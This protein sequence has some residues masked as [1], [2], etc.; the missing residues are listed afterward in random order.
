[1]RRQAPFIALFLLFT[2]FVVPGSAQTIY[3]AL[4]GAVTDTTGSALP[5]ATVTALNTST[6]ISTVRKA[7]SSG[8]YIFTQ[9]QVGGPYTV[10][11]AST[12]F[13][14]FVATGLILN[15]ND[16]REVN[17]KL[18]VGSTAQTVEV[19]ASALQVETSSTQLQQVATE[20]QLQEIPLLGRDPAGLQKLQPGVVESSDRIG[21]YSSNGSQT[22]QNSYLLNGMDINDGAL[23]SEGLLINPDAL[24]EESIVTS[25]MNPE[26]ARNSGA[27]INQLIKAGSNQFHGSGFEFYRDTFLN[28][29]NYFSQIRPVYHQN[30][31]GGTLGGPIFKDRFFFFLAYQGYRH[32]T[33]ETENPTTFTPNQFAGNFTDDL[34]FS[35]SNPN[36]AG[37]TNNPIPV[38]VNGC[39]A[40]PNSATPT[41]WASCFN[42]GSVVIPTTEWNTIAAN[43]V[44]KYI[45]A[46]NT[47]SG[48]YTFNALN[49][50][51]QD[52]GIIR[53]DYTPS[54]R[55]AVWGAFI[56]QSSPNQNELS[57]G[58]GSFPGFGQSAAEHY[59]IANVSYTHTFNANLLNELRV[60]Y[61]RFNFSAVNPTPVQSPGTLGFHITPQNSLSGIPYLNIGNNSLFELGNSFEGPQPRLDTNLSYA[62]SVTWVRGN[63]SLKFGGMW[64][65]FRVH[66][67]F[68]LD[69]NGAYSYGGGGPYSSG[70]PLIDFVM[71]I[72]DT[73]TQ[74]NNGFIDAV[75]TEAYA[76]VQDNWKASPD[77]TLNLGLAW[78]AEEPN[79]NKQFSG[80]G[81]VCYQIS[82]ATS[83]VFPGGAPGLFYNGDPGCNEAGGP[84]THY[85]HFAPKVGFAWSPSSGPAAL[86]G[87]PGSHNFSIRGAFGVYFNRD[88]EEQSLQN[89]ENPPAFFTSRGAGDFG[90]SPAFGN[91]FADVAGNGFET[92][93]FPYTAPSAGA[94]VNWNLYNQLDL[95]AFSKNYLVPYTYNFNLNIQR[96]IGSNMV[97]QIGYVGSLSHRLPTW[98]EG[99]PITQAGHDAC[100]ANAACNPNTIHQFFPQYT[101]NPAIVPGTAN[102][103]LPNGLPWYYS[104]AQQNTEGSSNYNSLQASLIK[105]PTHGLQFTLSYTYSHALDN[106]S[107]YESATGGD[108]GYG[109]AGRVYNYVPGFQAL[110]YGSSDFDARHRFVASYV[111]SVPVMSFMKDNF[112]LRQALSGWGVAGVTALQ[113]GFPIGLNMGAYRSYWCDA[114]SYFGC[115]D[116]PQV[117]D[118]NEKIFNPR[119]TPGVNQYFDTT[120]ISAE[121]LGTFG[122]ATRNYFHG[123]GFNYTNLSIIKGFPLSAEN[124][125]R[126]ELRLEAYNVFNHANFAPPVNTFNSPQF[127]QVTSVIQS[128]EGNGDP[129][130]GRSIQLAGKFYF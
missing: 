69:N 125:Q 110:N 33:A 30:L 122:N 31:Y 91:P 109:N 61:F 14:S 62:D 12:G 51:A 45:P 55:D 79:Q 112:V 99:D 24:H 96:A 47:P 105:A 94:A 102:A 25:T 21:N 120:N 90:G 115:A 107:G 13:Q 75:A 19:S 53:L 74:T 98:F 40:N 43:M 57:F 16:N 27:V 46:S 48:T 106:A 78:D 116:V 5:G 29:G 18:Q 44:N 10:T 26:Y 80:L 83:Q 129:S 17:G 108:S 100:L 76:Y 54:D 6:G 50:G 58:G 118:F 52:Q 93:P 34:N 92:N 87:E 8:Y 84:T 35:S 64:E 11:I 2:S 77:L 67:P 36:S 111:Y 103:S 60:G 117:S 3:A 9:L 28:N 72:P 70:D 37:L 22:P 81:I 97:A 59:K 63:H 68:G 38:N 15:A 65:Q 73:Y 39:V 113:T 127:G 104:V 23:Q 88:Q 41:T 20:A 42:N 32:R 124:K 121:P 101:A 49:T 4:H 7:D 86:I 71:G 85:D 89:L 126:V 56:V 95:S 123:P 1:M 66:N 114:Y 128:A 130:P 82:S 119:S